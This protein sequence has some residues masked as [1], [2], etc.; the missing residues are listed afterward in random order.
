VLVSLLRVCIQR[1][2]TARLSGDKHRLQR[3][4]NKTAVGRRRRRCDDVYGDCRSV[5]EEEIW[6]APLSAAVQP[7][8]QA[9]TSVA[10]SVCPVGR[11]PVVPGI[12]EPDW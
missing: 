1:A 6:R 2:F 3:G 11:H 10:L 7:Q 8:D 9:T 5:V 4:K 12:L